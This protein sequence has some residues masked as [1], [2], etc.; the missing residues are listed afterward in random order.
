MR[1]FQEA[2]EKEIQATIG[3]KLQG[4]E[5]VGDTMEYLLDVLREVDKQ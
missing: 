5:R 2:T 4:H 3:I 1:D